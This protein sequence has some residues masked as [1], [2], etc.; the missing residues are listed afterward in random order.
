[1]PTTW[2]ALQGF[3][4]SAWT[5]MGN[6]STLYYGPEA[7]WSTT[8]SGSTL[9]F[10]FTYPRNEISEY[11]LLDAQVQ[12]WGS[13]PRPGGDPVARGAVHGPA[14]PPSPAVTRARELLLDFLNELQQAQYEEMGKFDIAGSDGTLYRIGPGTNGNVE[15]IDP[16]T[17]QVKGRLCAHPRAYDYENRPIPE[18]DLHLGQLLALTTDERAWLEVA[19][20]HRGDWPPTYRE[21]RIEVPQVA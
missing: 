18:P 4:T 3:N 5:V 14:R 10:N 20:L 12:T 1:M 17:G 19:N 16:A 2:R 9:T 21:R 15:W 13:T 8:T 7:I 11:R 6:T